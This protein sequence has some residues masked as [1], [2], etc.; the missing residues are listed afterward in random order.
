MGSSIRR[1]LTYANVVAT[2]AL[3]FAMSGSAL[4]AKHYLIISTKQIKPSV[5]KS[6]EGRAGAAGPH[7][8]EGAAG[9]EGLRGIEGPAGQEGLPGKEGPRGIKGGAGLIRWRTTIDAP[10]K[11]AKEPETVEL[12][13]A[14]PFT[15]TGHCFTSGLY[16][17]AATYIRTS[18]NGSYAAGAYEEKSP[19]NVADGD[20]QMSGSAEGKTAEHEPQFESHEA[21]WGAEAPNGSMALDGFANQGVWI[22]GASGPACSFSGFLVVE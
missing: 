11:S 13:T 18:E 6:L 19:L 8:S 2:M 1:H 16:T 17:R 10:G 21:S 4:A 22:Q 15:I 7:G 3:V 14:G 12:A 20:V 5:L 9:K